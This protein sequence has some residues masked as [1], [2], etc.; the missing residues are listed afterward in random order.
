MTKYIKAEF[1][2]A[3]HSP[4]YKKFLI[5]C[6]GMMA[7]L[8]AVWK[9]FGQDYVDIM[10]GLSFLAIVAILIVISIAMALAFKTKDTRVQ[11]LSFGMT[12]S[13]MYF[14]D[15][16]TMQA[17]SVVTTLILGAMAYVT[18][19][20]A[21][22]T[23]L[24]PVPQGAY[25]GFGLFLVRLILLSL[26]LN[27]AIFG[28]SYLLNS[29]ALGIIGH[30]AIIPAVLNIALSFTMEKPLGQY[31]LKLLQIQPHNLLQTFAPDGFS[32]DPDWPKILGVG[33]IYVL[34]G[35]LIPG[36]IAF[37]KREIY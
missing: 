10:T 29:Q 1:Y 7:L 21:D 28:L 26:N 23:G 5:F 32:V 16:V 6:V 31:I 27:N 12:R 9:P 4:I 17:I 3:F 25:Q 15:L 33:V 19:F 30:I 11:I 20:I 34:V 24:S 2:R 36:L 35:F 14:Y 18:A 37:R 13:Q 22:L 8:L